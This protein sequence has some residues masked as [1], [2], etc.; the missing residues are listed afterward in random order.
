MKISRRKNN[1][2]AKNATMAAT[3]N[4]ATGIDASKLANAP[5]NSVAITVQTSIAVTVQS[6]MARLISWAR[7]E[8]VASSARTRAAA[9]GALAGSCV[10]SVRPRSMMRER[11][12]V[13]TAS[14]APIPERRNTGAT[15]SW[16]AWA[17]PVMPGDCC[18][19]GLT[20]AYV[21]QSFR[22]DL[23][24]APQRAPYRDAEL[25]AADFRIAAG[26]ELRRQTLA[27][28]AIGTVT[29]RAGNVADCVL[30]KRSRIEH[31]GAPVRRDVPRGIVFTQTSRT[32]APV[33]RPR[34]AHA[35]T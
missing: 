17:T 35:R 32:W 20:E 2:P 9:S 18:T 22:L 4:R 27:L 7:R 16:I 24:D 14:I 26:R 30:A 34:S 13:S 29:A 10:S 23:R 11:R 5:R 19:R 21:A 33:Y 15:A 28:A 8:S 3:K 25:V 1:S 6:V 31:E 12:L